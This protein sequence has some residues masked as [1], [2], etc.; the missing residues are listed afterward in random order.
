MN[1]TPIVEAILA[2]VA[3]IITVF[4]IPWIKSKTTAQQREDIVAWVN[5]AVS[6]AEQIYNGPGRGKEKKKYVINYLNSKGFKIDEAT[7]DILIESAVLK[8]N[9]NTLVELVQDEI[10]EGE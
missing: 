5:V 2:L 1:I 8:L 3:A 9:S 10:K 7:V 6:A 4:V